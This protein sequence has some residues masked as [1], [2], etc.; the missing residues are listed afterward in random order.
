MHL[1]I[2][3][4]INFKKFFRISVIPTALCLALA[5]NNLEIIAIL[6]I[7]VATIIYLFM[8]A[9]G[10]YRL[11][12]NQRSKSNDAKRKN[13]PF[14]FVGKLVI[15][16]GAIIFGVQIM[17]NRIIIPILNYTIQI[18]VLVYSTKSLDKGSK[19]END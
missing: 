9:E 12:E 3:K 7:Y 19:N 5:K 16:V 15:L 4:K 10:V 17:G 2:T 1:E 8:F 18:F 13:I 6:T 11:T 14:F